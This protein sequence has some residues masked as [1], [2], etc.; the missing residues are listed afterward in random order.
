MIQT[1]LPCFRKMLNI[2]QPNV[3]SATTENEEPYSL[4]NIMYIEFQN[5][6][7]FIRIYFEAGAS[8]I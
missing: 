7:F 6:C 3:K 4:S 5:W 8:R 2:D 1:I